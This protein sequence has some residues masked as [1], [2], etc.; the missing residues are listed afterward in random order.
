M[1]IVRFIQK[2]KDEIVKVGFIATMILMTCVMNAMDIPVSFSFGNNN[3]ENNYATKRRTNDAIFED[4]DNKDE[5]G[6]R[7]LIKSFDSVPERAIVSISEGVSTT[8][9]DYRISRAADDIYEIANRNRKDNKIVSTAI[10]ELE[11]LIKKSCSNHCRDYI[12]KLIKRLCD[13]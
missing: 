12:T 13:D 11:S 8:D 1:N 5:V 10:I 4:D 2:H 7:T 3:K 9:S 6:V